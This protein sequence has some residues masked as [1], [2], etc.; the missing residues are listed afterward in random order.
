MPSLKSRALNL[1]IV[2]EDCAPPKEN[3][4]ILFVHKGQ[5][6]D[7]IDSASDWWFAR[8]V[9]DITPSPGGT[10]IAQQGWVPGSFLDKF[11]GELS[12]EE[13]SAFNAGNKFQPHSQ[14][15]ISLIPRPSLASFQDHPGLA[16]AFICCIVML[17]L[18]LYL[19]LYPALRKIQLKKQRAASESPR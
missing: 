8:L 14:S 17:E 4:G 15:T 3:E 10:R 1:Y 19:A 6:Y 13:E 2:A 16:S 18:M 7:I 5:V 11:E 9:R 12:T